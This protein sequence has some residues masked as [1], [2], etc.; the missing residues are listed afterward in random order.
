L[1]YFIEDTT[2]E[3]EQIISS[4]MFWAGQEGAPLWESEFDEIL[5]KNDK[6]NADNKI[7]LK[8]LESE[9]FAYW[10]EAERKIYEGIKNNERLLKE[11]L[12]K[13]NK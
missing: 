11:L 13:L 8:S 5:I 4:W 9:D 2:K 1:A 10:S 6:S 12:E 3:V 7:K